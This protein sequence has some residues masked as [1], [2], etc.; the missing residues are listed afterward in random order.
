MHRH[1]GSSVLFISAVASHMFRQRWHGVQGRQRGDQAEGG[2]GEGAEGGDRG[3]P[4]QQ[5]HL[6]ESRTTTASTL[7]TQGPG[8]RISCGTC[9]W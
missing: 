8:L 2:A 7:S 4:S 9:T 3:G 5:G 6:A 1:L